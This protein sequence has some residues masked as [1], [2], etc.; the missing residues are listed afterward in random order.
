MRKILSLCGLVL[1]AGSL[2]A[3][4]AQP[5]VQ[6]RPHPHGR[7]AGTPAPG[8]RSVRMPAAQASGFTMDDIEYWVG[9]GTNRALLAVQW[10]DPRETNALAWGYR[11]DGEKCGIDAVRDIAAADPAFYAML[12][13]TGSLGYTVCGLGYDRDGDGEIAL[14]NK[15]TGEIIYPTEP[16]IFINSGQYDYDNYTTLDEDDYWG[17]GWYESYWSYWTADGGE[18]LSYS[19]LGA[20]A[21]KLT[22]GS[23][24]GWNFALGMQSYDF[25]PFAPAPAPGYTSGDF[26]FR[27]DG[28]GTTRLDYRKPSGDW[29]LDIF[30][31]ANGGKSLPAFLEKCCMFSGKV[32]QLFEKEG[33]VVVADG[34]KLAELGRISLESPRCFAGITAG[35]GYIGT[36]S[37]LVPVD[38]GRLAAGAPLE[39]VATSGCREL[40]TAQGRL[41]ILQDD[42]QIA[43][44]D[45]AIDLVQT[46]PADSCTALART[47][48]GAVW[49]ARPGALLRIDPPTLRTEEVRLPQYACP[50][51]HLTGDTEREALYFCSGSPTDSCSVYRYLP[52]DAAS[53][54][55]PL[56]SLDEV[57]YGHPRFAG[58]GLA[59][60]A[61]E[62]RLYALAR[63]DGGSELLYTLEA[64]TGKVLAA[65]ENDG[66]VLTAALLFPDAAPAFSGLPQSLEF[67]LDGTAQTLDLAEA[68]SDPDDPDTDLQL[69][70]TCGDR[71]LLQ[72]ALSDDRKLTVAPAAGQSGETEVLLALTSRGVTVEKRIAVLVRRALDGIEIPDTI[73]L[74]TGQ[75]DTLAVRFLPENAT[76]KEI[77]WKY[78]NYSTA[79]ISSEGVLTARKAGATF[80][81]AT[82]ED[83]GFTDTCRVFISDQPVTGLRLLHDTLHLFVNRADTLQYEVLPADASTQTIDWEVA[84]PSVASLATYSRRIEGLRE[85]ATWVY[86]TSRDG[87]FRDS[88]LVSV[89]FRPALSVAIE[90]KE[91]RLTA[92]ESKT[93]GIRLTPAD[94]SNESFTA[95][96]LAPAVAEASAYANS[97][98]PG[99][100]V[101]GLAAGEAQ[102]VVQSDDDPRL[103]AI[104]TAHVSY[105]PVEGF[106]FDIKDTTIA[107]GRSFSIGE[108]FTPSGGISNDTVAYTSSDEAVATVSASG[109]V[110]ALS[111][112][113]ALITGRTRDGGL[114]DSCRVSVVDSIRLEGIAFPR[115]EYVF[116]YGTDRSRNIAATRTPADATNTRITYAADNTEVA[117]VSSA[118]YLT[119]RGAG[120]TF[121]TAVSQ[122]GGYRDTCAVVVRPAAEEVL[123]P[124]DTLRMAPGDSLPLA[125]DVLPAGANPACTWKSLDATVATADSAGTV[126]ALCAGR[127]QV[128]A[129]AINGAADTCEIIVRNQPATGV[130]LDA[131]EAGLEE[132]DALQLAALVL[133]ANTTDPRLRWTSSNHAVASVSAQGYVKTFAEGEAT[134][135]VRTADGSNCADSC[136]VTVR[137]VPGTGLE[138]T[139]AGTAPYRAYMQEGFLV[140][141]GCAGMTLLLSDASGRPV[142][143]LRPADARV[144]YPAPPA[145]GLYFLSGEGK[146][147]RMA[148]KIIVG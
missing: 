52:G 35:K 59:L 105:I 19:G 104:L 36:A 9:E 78:D 115:A 63:T 28:T 64:A 102:I 67:E 45:P 113:E 135:Y 25:K 130:A 17:A 2:F 97:A 66:I 14:R 112:G 126:R 72:T 31:A 34:K 46:L 7:T 107:K 133:P 136:L 4:Q 125:A 131:H 123:L 56:F 77:S 103:I 137:R 117:T 80:V 88:C 110:R 141:E 74:K 65:E 121:V 140:V 37:G 3:Q 87:G 32:L 101:K 1:A 21:R 148:A 94:A 86:A 42:G 30:A 62:G 54:A 51:R 139:A 68:C 93:L 40:L 129:T 41:F 109:Y 49:A 73:Y 146:K 47:R 10:N 106:A 89:T 116:D 91:V 120:Q 5:T 83:G 84:D 50:V 119:V 39:G 96:S 22:D 61:A 53:L 82:A 132:G 124:A 29:E 69:S 8:S 6:G 13:H 55:A 24:D 20:S 11:F 71:E 26:F 38:L 118:G 44:L 108:V 81:T 70:A 138:G 143:T 23:C 90:E 99:V 48:S 100:R 43:V 111:A 122:E 85:G 58:F 134:I 57:R 95:Y 18:A 79:S 75:K 144:L 27:T 12:Q 60:D 128:V 15:A 114:A 127:A 145:P 147:G 92:P 142:H 16:G 98:G 76:D 33:V